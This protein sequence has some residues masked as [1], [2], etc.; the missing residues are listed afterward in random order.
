MNIATCYPWTPPYNA[1]MSQ[2]LGMLGLVPSQVRGTGAKMSQALC[3]RLMVVASCKVFSLAFLGFEFCTCF[4]AAIC[5]Y[6]MFTYHWVHLPRR[7]VL[8]KWNSFKRILAALIPFQLTHMR[9]VQSWNVALGRRP[10]P[11]L[12]I[13]LGTKLCQWGLGRCG[14]GHRSWPHLNWWM[15]KGN[16]SKG[17]LIQV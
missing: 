5:N 1:S 17:I 6:C 12:D 16:I 9:N 2:A 14:G 10:P 3:Y 15:G 13:C 4:V 8:F 7:N 11:S